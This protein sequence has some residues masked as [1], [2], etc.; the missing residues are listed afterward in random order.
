MMILIGKTC[1]R[2]VHSELT[3]KRIA[4][5]SCLLYNRTTW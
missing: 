5:H 3:R 2:L 4:R 1:K